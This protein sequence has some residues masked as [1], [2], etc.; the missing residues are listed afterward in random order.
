VSK[1]IVINLFGAPNSGKST[2]AAGLYYKL[3]LTGRPTEMVREY[4]K[5]LAWEGRI[6]G[7]FDQPYIFGKQLKYESMLYGKV[8]FLVTDSPLL[9][10]AYYDN[11]VNNSHIVLNAARDFVQYAKTKDV[12]FKNVFLNTV[13]T[14][15]QEGRFQSLEEVQ[16]M[17]GEMLTWLVE[18]VPGIDMHLIAGGDADERIVQLLSLLNLA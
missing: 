3:K 12:E 16:K 14:F 17:S 10:S 6:P 15:Q 8:D 18:N 11:Y 2:T 4:A 9:M 13:D 7:Q 5:G 1:T